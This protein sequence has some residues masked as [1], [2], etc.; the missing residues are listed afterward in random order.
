[1]DRVLDSIPGSQHPS[2]GGEHQLVDLFFSI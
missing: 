1:M 2:E